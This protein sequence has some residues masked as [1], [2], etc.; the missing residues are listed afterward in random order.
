MSSMDIQSTK[1]TKIIYTGEG[2]YDS[3][4]EH[5]AKYLKLN[6]TYTV[7]KT[8]ISQSSTKVI[9]QEFPDQKFNSVHFDD[10][11]TLKGDE[12]AEVVFRDPATKQEIVMEFKM[13]HTDKSVGVKIA[14]GD[15]GPDSH[16]GFYAQLANTYSKMMLGPQGEPPAEPNT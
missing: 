1:G 15:A 11:F 8:E 16:T 10:T 13:D 3:D 5:A 12:I 14:F 7:E 2:G 4:K 9:L 6:E